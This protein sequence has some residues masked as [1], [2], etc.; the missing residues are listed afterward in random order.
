MLKLAVLIWIVLGTTLAG[1]FVTVVLT[2]PALYAKA[3]E[4]IPIAAGAGFVVAI[5]FAVV[6]AKK[7]MAQIPS[8]T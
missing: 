6:I 7:I 1:S 2:V 8:R 5:P 4:N 3:M